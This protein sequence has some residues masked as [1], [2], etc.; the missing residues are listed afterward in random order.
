MV[1][2]TGDVDLTGVVVTDTAAPE[3][4][5]ATAEGATVSGTTATWNLG[6]LKAGEKKNLTVK[7]LSKVPGRFCDTA[8]V[9]SDPGPQGQRPGL[10]RVEGRDGR[11]VGDGGRS[12]SD[13]GGRDQQVHHQRDQPGFDD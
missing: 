4:V 9:T 13:P 8:S 7:V 10:H 2:N 5:I 3:T 11:A 12:G 1:S 6:T